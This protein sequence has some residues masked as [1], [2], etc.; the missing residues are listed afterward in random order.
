MGGA[1]ARWCIVD[2]DIRADSWHELVVS[3]CARHILFTTDGN[4]VQ[5]GNI[6]LYDPCGQDIDPATDAVGDVAI[7]ATMQ[8]GMGLGFL[9]QH[10]MPIEHLASQQAGGQVVKIG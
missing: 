4:A 8:G 5:T 3:G 6:H 2:Q 9:G 10:T 7:S 1:A